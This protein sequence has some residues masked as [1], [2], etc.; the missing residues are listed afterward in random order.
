MK[1]A[2][3][4]S[5]KVKII[6]LTLILSIIP[7]IVLGINNLNSTTNT[8]RESEIEKLSTLTKTKEA[9][10]EDY[11]DAAIK[12]AQGLAD[13]QAVHDYINN[14]EQRTEVT[15][16]NDQEPVDNSQAAL[17]SLRSFQEANWG[18]YHHIYI[19]NKQ[20]K[21]ILS[22]P[23]G[24][25]TSSHK[26][27]DISKSSYFKAAF[28]TAQVTDFFGFEE[29]DHY[30]S[31]LIQPIKINN[32]A[33]GFLVF[34]LEIGHITEVLTKNLELGETG[35]LLLTTSE[36]MPIVRNKGEEQEQ[37]TS[38]GI[39]E[40]QENGEA[41]GIFPNQEGTNVIGVYDKHDIYPWIIGF[42]INE[43]ELLQSV[44]H[45]RQSTYLGVLVT[46]V[47]VII[48]SLLLTKVIVS[49][50]NKVASVL[51]NIAEGEGDL[52]QRLEIKSHD[53]IGHLAKYFNQFISNLDSLIG[54]LRSEAQTIASTS[55]QLASSSQQ[56]NASTQQISSGVQQVA[57]SSESLA[58]QTET[59]NKTA[60]ELSNASSQGASAA[61]NAEDKMKSLSTAVGASSASVS[62]LGDKSQRIVNIIDTINNIASQTNLLALNAAIEAARA[63]EAGRGFAVV[64]DEVRKLAEESHN[65]TQEIEALI[66]EIK[67]STDEA[68]SS[69]EEGKKQVE[70]GGM[71]VEEALGSLE[72]MSKDIQGIESAIESLGAVAQQSA[73][74]SQQMNS[75][76][77]QTSSAMQQ[78]ASAA[79]QLAST[80]EQLENLVGKFK[81]SNN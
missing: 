39:I 73:S 61:K 50:I 20:G 21:V 13:S 69:M 52:T 28:D 40:A 6:S 47:I 9:S 33:E 4:L 22:P 10:L 14:T 74:S 25:S 32:Q 19:T 70:E 77:Q 34:E 44:N 18:R 64:A 35:K 43:E 79:Q 2:I 26:D 5:I 42:E 38:P 1:S 51:Q 11:L 8:L 31:I 37:L 12:S 49:P 81:I 66:T 15:Q 3:H 54:Q 23:H 68:V 78:V 29:A 24:D 17:N 71:V 60:K 30:H 55:Q 67:T 41:Q 46:M 80:S 45:I 58:K 7:I 53:E 62:D 65:A 75:G 76:I 72:T 57:S 63:G 56:V 27:Q 36:G 16:E 48:A 59:V